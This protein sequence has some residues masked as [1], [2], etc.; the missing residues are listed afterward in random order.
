MTKFETNGVKKQ[1]DAY[2]KGFADKAFN[3]SCYECS[4]RGLDTHRHGCDNCPIAVAHAK[5]IKEIEEGKRKPDEK[6][7]YG[8]SK[9][10][11]GNH[12]TTVMYN[13][14]ITVNINTNNTKEGKSHE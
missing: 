9:K 3:Y 14:N 12:S 5:A 11:S 13:F 2:L 10:Y 4:V 1:E 6:F 7:H 8:A